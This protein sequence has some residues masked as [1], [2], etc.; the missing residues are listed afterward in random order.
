ML[1]CTLLM[2]SYVFKIAGIAEESIWNTITWW[3]FMKNKEMLNKGKPLHYYTSLHPDT[4][5]WKTDTHLLDSARAEV[6]CQI[7]IVGI[8]HGVH[9]VEVSLEESPCGGLKVRVVEVWGVVELSLNV[10]PATHVSAHC[11]Q[12][13]LRPHHSLSR[14]VDLGSAPQPVLQCA[15]V[16]S[17]RLMTSIII[18]SSISIL[19][20]AGRKLSV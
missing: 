15:T 17:G 12:C 20:M 16:Y 14:Q 3:N 8:F 4:L 11:L 19:E 6:R 7:P 2:V 9:K 5:A 1:Q 10:S 18:L 13:H